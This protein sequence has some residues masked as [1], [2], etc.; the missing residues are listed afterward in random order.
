MAEMLLMDKGQF[1][2]NV[3]LFQVDKKKKEVLLIHWRQR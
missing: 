2:V 1:A 3:F